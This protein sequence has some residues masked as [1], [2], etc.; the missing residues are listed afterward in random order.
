MTDCFRLRVQ[1]ALTAQ[2]AT[3]TPDNGYEFDLTGKVFRGRDVF[4]R[5]DPLPMVS[6]LESINEKDGL[7]APRA[8]TSVQTVWELLIQGWTE[9]DKANPTD[10]GQ[11]LMAEVKKCLTEARR[12]GDGYDILGQGGKVDSIKF[13]TGVVRPAD[14]VSSKA[15]FWLKLELG[16]VENLLDP[17]A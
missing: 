15:Y 2:L 10:P 6:I 7:P 17:Y 11:A 5:N 12:Q 8:G 14:D 13:S 3:I 16:M 9:D 4:D 1:K